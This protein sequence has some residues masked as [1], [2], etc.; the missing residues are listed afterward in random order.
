MQNLSELGEEGEGPRR[1][2]AEPGGQALGGPA[3]PLARPLLQAQ[4]H[5]ES[6]PLAPHMLPSISA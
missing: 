1:V 2:Q 6:S 3:H 5:V 4:P